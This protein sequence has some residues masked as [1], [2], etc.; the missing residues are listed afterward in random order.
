MTT[1]NAAEPKITGRHQACVA[2]IAIPPATKPIA[3]NTHATLARILVAS[4][5]KGPANTQ[6]PS[7]QTIPG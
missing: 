5:P 4:F 2:N 3:A 7:G 6:E 1:E